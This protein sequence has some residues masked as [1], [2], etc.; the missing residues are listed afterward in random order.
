M[1]KNSVICKW[2][3]P[4]DDGG[5][6]IINYTLENK[7]NSKMEFG[8]STVTS[9]LMGCRYLVPKLI[10]K[11]EYIFRVVA[12]NKF[13][14]GRPCVSKPLIAKNPFGEF[15]LT[16]FLMFGSICGKY[17]KVFDRPTS[18]SLEPPDAPDKPQIEDITAN[19]MLVKWNQPNDNGSPILGYW[20]ERREIN[21]S[22]WAR[23]NRFENTRTPTLY[24]FLCLC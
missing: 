19:S 16:H 13:G 14:P 18:L 23:A 21:S 7:D 3:P 20:V 17:G 10:E 8:W 6:E 22:H 9:T 5:S 4:L 24:I 15:T 2:D 11:K 12:E 1:R